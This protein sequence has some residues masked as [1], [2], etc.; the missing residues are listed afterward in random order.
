MSQQRLCEMRIM[1]A[2]VIDARFPKSYVSKNEYETQGWGRLRSL[3]TI[4]ILITG[5]R[6]LL[7]TITITII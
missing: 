4:M 7:I 2:R 5:H 3:I 6:K 1:N